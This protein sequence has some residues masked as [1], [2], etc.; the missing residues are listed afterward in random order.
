MKTS[1]YALVFLLAI[2]ILLTLTVL[3]GRNSAK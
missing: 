1:N 2:L 3:L